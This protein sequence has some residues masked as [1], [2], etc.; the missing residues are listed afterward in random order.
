M[1]LPVSKAGWAFGGTLDVPEGQKRAAEHKA[2]IAKIDSQLA[3]AA[4][5]SPT[6]ALLATGKELRK[7]WAKLTPGVRGE[8]INEIAV[9]TIHPCGR[10]RRTFDPN[11]VDVAWKS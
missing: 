6:A 9:V 2:E 1:I 3:Q 8:I 10:G 7:R 5:T 4:R 11:A